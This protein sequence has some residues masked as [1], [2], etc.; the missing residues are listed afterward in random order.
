MKKLLAVV[1]L[2][3]LLLPISAFADDSKII[4]CWS[5]YN[6]RTDGAP[7]IASLYLSENNVCYYVIQSFSADDVSLG[8]AFVGTWSKNSD[9]SITAKTGQNT[10]VT[11]VFSPQGGAALNLKTN[12]LFINLK[13]F[14]E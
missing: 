3:A 9:G 2:L 13:T 4:G 12:E 6:L 10:E 7:V 8:R 1:L 14:M 11:L 5:T